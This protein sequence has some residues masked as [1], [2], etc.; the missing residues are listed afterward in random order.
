MAQLF[1]GTFV[2]A[3]SPGALRIHQDHLLAVSPEG[4]I[5]AFCPAD[6]AAL[7]AA[8]SA[9]PITHLPRH[10]FLLPTFTDLHLH[11]PQYLYAGTGLDLPLMEW[12]DKYTYVA[13]ER[14]DSDEELAGRVYGRLMERL[15]RAGTGCVVGF[16]TIGVK[17]NL[18]LAEKFIEAGLRG[19]VGKLSMDK[20]P[21]SR[22]ESRRGAS[23]EKLMV[24]LKRPTYGEPSL[25]AATRSIHAYLDGMEGLAASDPLGLVKPILTP[26]FVPVCSDELL[27][28]IGRISQERGVAVQSHM[29]E[30]RDQMKWVESTRGKRDEE[31]FDAAGLLGPQTIQAHVTSLSG[32]LIQ[33]VKERGVTIAHCPLSNAY[34]SDAQFPLREAIDA[35]LLVGLGSDIAGGYALSIQTAMR[36]AVVVARIREGTRQ[37]SI[38]SLPHSHVTE[39]GNTNLRVDWKESLYLATRGGKK[40]LGMGGCWE[41]GM[42]F[43]A[44]LIELA[45]EE[46]PTGT[47]LLDL[48]D[49]ASQDTT[50]EGWWVEM[51][52]RWW[53]NGNEENRKGMWIQGKR[54]FE[55]S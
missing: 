28:T 25:G 42:E 32:E 13:E 45:G 6:D 38:H 3:P 50:R 23:G 4:T 53:C 54:V 20:S 33:L 5:T 51:V 9:C 37:E 1:R 52:E 40:A 35:E 27:Q 18:I 21:V 2:D 43:D 34:F 8:S 31:V 26:R 49:I 16:G 24:N 17:A 48:F 46:N 55:A 44:Q 15:K 11:C 47:G 30:S 19:F 10:S 7:S 39:A 22:A 12:L 36:Q 14:I 41:V 29:C